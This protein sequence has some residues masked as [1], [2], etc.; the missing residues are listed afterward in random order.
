MRFRRALDRGNVTEAQPRQGSLNACGRPA[1]G[2]GESVVS[3]VRSAVEETAAD[4]AMRNGAIPGAGPSSTSTAGP[5]RGSRA[6]CRRGG[7]GEGRATDRHRPAGHGSLGFSAPP[8]ACRLA[9]RRDRGGGRPRAGPLRC[10]G[11]LRWGPLRRRVRLET[12]G[13]ANAGRTRELP[14]A[15]RRPRRHRR[16]EPAEPVVLPTGGPSGHLAAGPF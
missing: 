4:W 1:A 5:A 10:P 15:A 3:R 6:P 14:H 12:L 2:Y 16:H 9:R 8:H 13:S 11:D 7:E